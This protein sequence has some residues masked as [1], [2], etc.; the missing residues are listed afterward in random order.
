MERTTHSSHENV[1][2]LGTTDGTASGRG[3]AVQIEADR[4]GSAKI[5]GEARVQADAAGIALG[6]TTTTSHK[7]PDPTTC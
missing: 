1:A 4:T 2:S 7:L 6:A 3:N 5:G